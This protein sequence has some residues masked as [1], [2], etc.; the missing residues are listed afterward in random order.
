MARG[1]VIYGKKIRYFID[2]VEC[3]REEFD[4]RF[5]PKPIEVPN[6]LMETSKAWPRLSDSWGVGKGQK[7]KAEET[8]RKLGVPTEYVPDGS[9]GY[10]AK[11][12]NNEHQR[13]LLKAT[14]MHNNDGGYGQVTG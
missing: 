11:I 14:G 9:G 3:T 7:E 10:S 5:P 13:K 1:T 12:L 4:E 6:A 8:M 2:Q